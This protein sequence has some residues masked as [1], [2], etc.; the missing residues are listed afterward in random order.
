MKKKISVLTLV[1]AMILCIQPVSAASLQEAVDAVGATVKTIS[2]DANGGTG[3]MESIS[4]SDVAALPANTFVRTDFTFTGWNTKADGK[5][6]SYANGAATSQ[7]VQ[8][9]NKR[10][11]T[12]Y[13][14]WKISNAPK[15][16][17]L[18]ATSTPGALQVT[19]TGV[20]QATSY[21]IQYSTSSN[22]SKPVTIPVAKGGSA[23]TSTD[24][25]PGKVNYVR[26]RSCYVDANTESYSDWSNVLSAKPKKGNTI[27][28]AKSTYA[29]EADIC[30]KGS[31]S[32]Y[33]AKLVMGTA[34]SAVSFGIQYDSCAVAPYTGKT[35][36][37]IENV[38]SNNP[39]GQKYTRPK[40]KALK[41]GKTYH[42]MMTVDKKGKV[43]VY[44]DYKKIGSV[45][46]SGLKKGAP[47][48][49]I[50]ACARLNGD[51]VNATFKNIKCKAGGTYDPSRQWNQNP[52]PRNKG[53]KKKVK[54]N[55]AIVFSGKIKGLSA[56]QDWD[57]AYD[58]VSYNI[59]FY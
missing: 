55:G 35:M 36:A 34:V 53:L 44:L 31:G 40:N 12:L 26:M 20:S 51:K 46:N 52:I 21:E 19:Y 9:E 13:A 23:V 16:Q 50:E 1:L 3:S 5:G 29:I 11:I 17:G 25:M 18:K 38:A 33:H 32:G 15:L 30:L 45:T 58:N 2:F 39:G 56:G 10:S 57:N 8:S 27:V 14:Q 48:L 37:L 28:N 49:S 59:M 6:N 47:Y 7:I 41:R 42:L 54:K 24:F 22:F 4:P 43:T